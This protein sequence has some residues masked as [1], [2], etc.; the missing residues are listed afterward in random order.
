MKRI[1]LD[2]N[3]DQSLKPLFDKE[4]EVLTV[5]EHDWN[6]KKNG[7]LLKLTEQEFDVFVTMDRNLE[8]QQNLAALDLAVVVVQ[9]HSNAYSVVALLMTKINQALRQIKSGQLVRVSR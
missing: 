2:E 3:I 5:R 1:L 7:E 4:F 9:A 8:Y 6:G